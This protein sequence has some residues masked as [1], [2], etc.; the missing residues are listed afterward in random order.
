MYFVTVLVNSS[1]WENWN[2]YSSKIARDLYIQISW[3][4]FQIDIVADSTKDYQRAS[5]RTKLENLY[6]DF[7]SFENMLVPILSSQCRRRVSFNS[8]NDY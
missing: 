4:I 7:S 2:D 6:L 8:V 1:D 5:N 3:K